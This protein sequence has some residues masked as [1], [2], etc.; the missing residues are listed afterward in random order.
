MYYG[1]IYIGLLSGENDETL[2]G[3]VESGVD[4]MVEYHLAELVYNDLEG[5]IELFL[6]IVEM[7][8]GVGI[9]EEDE[10]GV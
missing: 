5:E 4:L 10:I 7:E 2:V 1:N 8:S 6:Q 3:L 9:K